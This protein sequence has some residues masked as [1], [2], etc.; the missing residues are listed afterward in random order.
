MGKITIR[1]E[2]ATRFTVAA[3]GIGI[4]TG[5]QQRWT[6]N[7]N[8]ILKM[9]D[10]EL[11][12]EY[13]ENYEVFDLDATTASEFSSLEEL[14]DILDTISFANFKTGEAAPG[15]FELQLTQVSTDAPT[16]LLGNERGFRG[17]TI[18]PS[19]VDV[20]KYDLDSDLPIFEDVLECYHEGNAIPIN[21]YTSILD[22]PFGVTVLTWCCYVVSPT[23]IRVISLDSVGGSMADDLISSTVLIKMNYKQ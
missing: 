13:H 20:G 7:G 15:Y 22:S 10:G 6:K 19:Y 2:S 9:P 17:A 21:T 1:K 5:V 3:D 4:V 23:K 16:I 18:T 8:V 12:D 14:L 11:V